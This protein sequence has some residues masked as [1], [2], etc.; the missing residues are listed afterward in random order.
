MASDD[1]ELDSV[2]SVYR[3]RSDGAVFP[4]ISTVVRHIYPFTWSTS[5]PAQEARA[6]E[7][8]NAG[9][10]MHDSIHR[11]FKGECTADQ[12]VGDGGH[13][14]RYI[15]AHADL[16]L[17]SCEQR[18]VSDVWRLGG[19]LDALFYDNTRKCH[20]LVDWK[21]TARVFD[22]SLSYYTL[23]LNLYRS[24]LYADYGLYV[25]QM[26]LVLLHPSLAGPEEIDVG[27][28]DDE[29]FAKVNAYVQT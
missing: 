2:E 20:V 9:V 18:I 11:Y 29:V 16:T 22:K 8:R 4:R 13:F 24:I 15:E 19:T 28:V 12:I 10:L 3:R 21:R 1:I 5:S 23:Q 17:V 27:C 25:D 7:A 14:R 6:E 26:V